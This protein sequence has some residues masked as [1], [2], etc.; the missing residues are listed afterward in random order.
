[1]LD[2]LHA[3]KPSQAE[4][5]HL[6]DIKS[7]IGNAPDCFHR[8]HFDPGHIT[9][10]GLLV[11]ADGARVLM[12]HHKFLNISGFALAVMRMANRMS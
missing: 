7:L 4:E 10:S 9:G 12:N 1:M 2:I 3:Y 5:D 8:T 6:R 11:S